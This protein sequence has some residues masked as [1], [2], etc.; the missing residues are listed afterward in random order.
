MPRGHMAGKKLG[1]IAKIIEAL[2]RSPFPQALHAIITG[3]HQ[4]PSGEFRA[5]LEAPDTLKGLQKR[6][7]RGV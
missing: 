4:Q 1:L 6:V 5:A 7:L 3:D 2:Q